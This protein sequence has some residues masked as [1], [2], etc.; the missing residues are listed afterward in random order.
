M[1][2]KKTETAKKKAVRSG[3]KEPAVRIATVPAKVPTTLTGTKTAPPKTKMQ[4]TKK[5]AITPAKEKKAAKMQDMKFPIV[6]IGASAGGLEALEGFFSHMPDQNN[7][8]IVV[9]QHLAPTYKSIMGNLLKKYTKMK[10]VDISDGMK[11]EK[12]CVYLNPP[13][14]DVAII[15]RTLQLIKPLETHA[16]R[17]PIDFFF[18]SLADD[19]GEK[20]ICIVLS[21]TGTDGTLGLKAVKGDGGMTM[22]QDETQARYDSMPRN[23][24]NT[25][26]VDF[27]LP[28]E[29]MPEELTKY[30]KHPYIESPR[31]AIT[32]EQKYQGYVTKI[33][34]Q[35]RALTG[36]DFSHYKQNTIRRR[37]ERRMAVHQIDKIAH[38]LDYL[39]VN[40]AEIDIL[41]KDMLI[42][43]TNF[44]RDQE[45]FDLLKKTAIFEILKGKR[46][47]SSIRVWAPGC[48]TGEE[49][50]SIA[51]LLAEIMD[52]R[53]M[54]Y[55]VQIFGTDLDADAIEFA[56]AGVYPES[57]AADVS[58]E[59][60]KQY[61]T[62]EENTYRLK[63]R[64]REMLVFATQNLIKD[65]PFSRL[66]LIS[67][68]NV[69]IYMDAFLQKKILP[70]FHYTLNKDGYLFLG[71]SESIGEFTDL[72]SVE[73]PKWKIYKRKGMVI[74]KGA[75]IPTMPIQGAIKTDRKEEKKDYREIN[76][77]QYAEKEI[78]SKYAPPF[79]LVN[80]KH[81][82][83]YVNGMIHKYLLTPPG[84]PSFNILKIAHEDLRYKLSTMLHKISKKREIHIERGL[85]I[86]D[87]EHFLTFDLT[88]KPLKPGAETEGLTIIIFEE[89]LPAEKAKKKEKFSEKIIKES[90]KIKALE[91]ELKSTKEYLQATIEELET[92]NEELKSTNEELQSTNEELQ[93]TNEELETSKEEQQSTNEELETVNS[94]LQNK[95]IELSRSNNDLN[96]LLASTEIAT[97][98]LDTRLNIIR[99]TPAITK[100]FNMLPSDIKRPI[101]DI[102]AKFNVSTLHNDA[103]E[104]LR[105]LNKKV[106]R[107]KTNDNSWYNMRILPYRTT[108]NLIDGIV[109]T[110]VD[111]TELTE[112][113]EKITSMGTFLKGNPTPMLRITQDGTIVFSNEAGLYLLEHWKCKVNYKLPTPWNTIIRDVLA[114]NKQEQRVEKFGEKTFLLVFVPIKE[115]AY[116]NIYGVDISEYQLSLEKNE[117]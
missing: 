53:Q 47:N 54:H 58:K 95:V 63:K 84:L 75:E 32:T 70:V 4:K 102:T 18:R 91:I 49:A 31:A 87:N 33:L 72:F 97:V 116:V 76:F 86:K 19:Q 61:F 73:N 109:I 101:G 44:F 83:L 7:L 111:I 55:N 21:G 34:L 20:A 117:K 65:P 45:A 66:D 78:L 48:S 85:K 23:A 90:P 50:Y 57:I 42:G 17:L 93:S 51:I 74:E 107:I 2:K 88:V 15:N 37:I 3:E 92:S 79:V 10:I 112:S 9:V 13:D 80:E 43:V 59:R 89:K 39:R 27:I 46:P 38:Y 114:S 26:A 68:R 110:F 5:Q 11:V 69:L 115:G 52:K 67:C 8:A 100:L 81:E 104:V 16:A 64:I 24:I 29:R 60:L 71:S 99:F 108:D 82:I 40:T 35:I 105:T 25:G 113:D 41:Y 106:C 94:E 28:V 77:I 103:A 6:G 1:A 14:M 56:R 22:V 98:F 30:I 12:N 96:N 36:H 62:K